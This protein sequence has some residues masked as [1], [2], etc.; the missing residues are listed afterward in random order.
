MPAFFK[1]DPEYLKNLAANQE[2]AAGKAAAAAT[3]VEKETVPLTTGVW[4]SHGLFSWASNDALKNA[5]DARRAA[6]K[7]MTEGSIELAAKVRAGGQTYEAVDEDLSINFKK[8][9]QN[10]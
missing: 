6:G 7:T 3:V 10:D 1:V 4:I 5:V 9:M 2:Q 8:Q